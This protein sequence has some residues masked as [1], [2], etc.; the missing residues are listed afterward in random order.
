MVVELGNG[1]SMIPGR[2]LGNFPEFELVARVSLSGGPAAQP[3][4]WFGSTIVRPAEGAEVEIT[5][6]TRVE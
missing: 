5:I 3:G 1:D 2:E 6:G 4:D